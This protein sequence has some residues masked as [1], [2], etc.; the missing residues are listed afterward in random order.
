MH[1]VYK[2]IL[3]EFLHQIP[4]NF[5]A[6]NTTSVC[7][8]IRSKLYVYRWNFV[9]LQSRN[10]WIG[11]LPPFVTSNNHACRRGIQFWREIFVETTFHAWSNLERRHTLQINVQNESKRWWISGESNSKWNDE[12]AR[13]MVK[14]QEK[15]F[16]L[17][18]AKQ[19]SDLST[20]T[21]KSSNYRVDMYVSE[22][23]IWR[24]FKVRIAWVSLTFTAKYTIKWR[25]H[26]QISAQSCSLGIKLTSKWTSGQ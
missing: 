22:K 25:N 5:N 1:S 12:I 17:A 9:T 13:V 4:F 10:T 2:A 19:W 3:L 15:L 18:L 20:I 21:R 14:K 26:G 11:K 6:K 8:I 7:L 24:R 16:C 23:Q